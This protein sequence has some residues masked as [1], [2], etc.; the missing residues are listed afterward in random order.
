MRSSCPPDYSPPQPTESSRRE[1]APRASAN[2]GRTPH[3]LLD[4]DM[5]R[6]AGNAG[7][8]ISRQPAA[9][10]SPPQYFNL[11]AV[12]Y[13]PRSA[14][15]RK[16]QRRGRVRR[17]ASAGA[18]RADREVAVATG[19]ASPQVPVVVMAGGSRPP[20]SG[21]GHREPPVDRMHGAQHTCHEEALARFVALCQQCIPI[22]AH[23]HIPL[24]EGAHRCDRAG[25][26]V[27]GGGDRPLRCRALLLSAARRT[28]SVRRSTTA[29]WRAR[30]SARRRRRL[31]RA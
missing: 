21:S 11:I 4:A 18:W 12:R 7:W 9:G 5:A 26:P 29:G 27:R 17:T 13:L 6:S 19:G 14:I 1:S 3:A 10:P 24:I 15:P 30:R 23:P 25:P 22:R 28:R 2:C 16:R 20:G 8:G 31:R